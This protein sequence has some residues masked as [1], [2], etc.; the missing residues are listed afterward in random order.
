MNDCQNQKQS[1]SA[2]EAVERINQL[3]IDL[4]GSREP[5]GLLILK[6]L[7]VLQA[8]LMEHADGDDEPFDSWTEMLN[9]FCQK[10]IGENN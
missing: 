6:N 5:A 4:E 7:L 9:S 10:M 1:I 3:V 8:V 2:E